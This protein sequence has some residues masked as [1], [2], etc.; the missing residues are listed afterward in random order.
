MSRTIERRIKDAILAVPALR[1]VIERARG[2]GRPVGNMATRVPQSDTDPL[3]PIQNQLSELLRQV[4]AVK[5]EREALFDELN[6]WRFEVT[7]LRTVRA[8]GRLIET[9]FPYFP[10]NRSW[11]GNPAIGRLVAQFEDD[12]DRYSETLRSFA[13]LTDDFLR[14]PLLPSEERPPAEPCWNN[15]WIPALDA[16][17]L[18]GYVATR[19]PRHYVEVGSGNSTKFVRKAIR[20]HGLRTKIISIDPMPR[21]EIDA[22]CDTVHRVGQEDIDIGFFDT[23]TAEDILFVDNSHRSFPNSDVTVFFMEVLGRL[24]KGLLFGLHD[25]FLPNDYPD[26]WG[27]RYYNEQYLLAAYLF[28]GAGGDRIDLPCAF[29][30]QRPD[31]L[32]LLDGVW[33]AK[34]LEG[35]YDHGGAFWMTKN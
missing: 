8:E 23:L 14:I 5:S 17:S 11:Q 27:P 25:I 35:I 16:I 24:P 1:R 34:H 28:G 12:S 7:H 13:R 32:G 31:L 21:A 33:K 2:T 9:D 26:E 6:H 29:I 15:G 20:D 18:Y 22:I 3:S 4:E 30:S 10:R 19:N